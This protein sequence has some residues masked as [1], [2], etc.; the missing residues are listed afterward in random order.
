M[1]WGWGGEKHTDVKKMWRRRKTGRAA[2]VLGKIKQERGDAGV[3]VTRTSTAG[4]RRK[5]QKL[6]CL[7]PNPLLHS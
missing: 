1:G 6:C 2:T 7:M 4:G 5:L 3:S